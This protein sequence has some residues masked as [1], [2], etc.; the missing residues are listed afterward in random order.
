MSNRHAREIAKSHSKYPSYLRFWGKQK[1][2]G[3]KDITPIRR[4]PREG[5]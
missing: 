4:T 3:P 1:G 2:Y 5:P